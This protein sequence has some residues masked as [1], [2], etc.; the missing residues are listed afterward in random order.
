M[1]STATT[2]L[3]IREAS[4]DERARWDDLVRR[5]P[6]HRVTHL[7]S[8]MD[9]LV[10]AGGGRALYLV[11]EKG[12]E[13]VGCL[14]GLLATLGKLKLYGSPLEGRQT[15]SMGPVFDP[16]RLTTA[17]IAETL[18][19]WLEREH[20][21]SHI[22]LML[23]GLDA[24]AMR[25]A[26]FEGD[27][28]FTWR[29][30]LTP[31]D[32]E[33]TFKAMK[34]SARRNVKR[35]QKLGIEIRNETDDA[36]V[37]E[38][39]EQLTE[40]YLRGG[41]II[42]FGKQ[43]ILSCFRQMRD[44]GRL[45]ALGAYLPGGRVCIATGMFFVEGTELYLWMWAHHEHYRWYRP[46]ELMTWTAMQ[47]GMARGCTSLDFMGRGDFKMRFGAE[48]DETKIRWLRSRPRWLRTARRVAGSVFH[49]QQAARGRI[50]RMAARIRRGDEQ[51]VP[52]CVM[53]DIDLVRALAL[54]GIPSAVFA[55]PGTPPHFS[56]A[57]ATSLPWSD[58]WQHGDD[59]IESLLAFSAEQREPPVLYYQDD[60]ALLLVSRNRERLA[61]AYRFVIPD[62]QLVEQLVDKQRFQQL[63]RKLELPVPPARSFC[64]VQTGFTDDGELRF[65]VI[66]K[67]LTR[68]NDVWLPLVGSGKAMS[69][70]TADALRAFWPRLAAADAEVMVQSRIDGPES[71]IESYHVYV[72]QKGQIAGEFTGRKVRT[73]PVAYGDTTSL[74]I[75]GAEDVE[76]LGRDIVKRL[77]LRGVAKLDFKRASDGTLFLLEVNPRFTLW[78]HAGAE[79]GVN[80]PALVH[81]DCTNGTRP[82]LTR[83]RAGVRWCKVWS[84]WPAA[85]SSGVPP[86]R[87]LSW[88]LGSEAKSAFAWD[89]PLPLLGAAASRMLGR[90]RPS[91]SPDT[92]ARLASTVAAERARPLSA[93]Q[94]VVP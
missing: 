92:S 76:A 93:I 58:P 75:T 18:V 10:A 53:G 9:S 14:P 90:S 89:D 8:W 4:A 55:A 67:P 81:A 28:V 12:G 86:L 51:P 33:R 59:V 43:R 66:V 46:T 34:D 24:D 61:G 64:A 36:F 48:P 85:R 83:A 60:R 50:G 20:G 88:A 70:D 91:T 77:R 25:T 42:P 35:A 37:D 84:D 32:P 80:L 6:G 19:P 57:V 26:G 41:N 7:S 78:N 1:I 27:S 49:V 62:A 11:F 23:A 29:A 87:W 72:D 31:E 74:E 21:V 13:I 40:V 73:W 52:A 16:A 30:A 22:E 5:F 38:H 71:A 47:Q 54:A 82:A 65:P 68:R 3:V 94:E 69:F 2:P 45:I 79:A 44:A 56:R 39:Y 63:A 15:V 17:E